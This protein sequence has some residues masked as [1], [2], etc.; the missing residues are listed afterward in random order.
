MRLAGS[1]GK[2]DGRTEWVMVIADPRDASASKNSFQRDRD[3]SISILDLPMQEEHLIA[4]TQKGSKTFKMCTMICQLIGLV[5]SQFI[6]SASDWKSGFQQSRLHSWEFSLSL[7]T[8]SP[9]TSG[10]LHRSPSVANTGLSPHPLHNWPII[11][12]KQMHQYY[13]TELQYIQI[14]HVAW[15]SGAVYCSHQTSRC[16]WG[17]NASP[18][19]TETLLQTRK[20]Q[21]L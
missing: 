11:K 6:W 20:I 12:C 14:Q 15:C 5:Q 7:C 17:H 2:C 9:L 4:T 3:G 1:G 13:M 10:L 19:V 16:M 21:N 18:G 8:G